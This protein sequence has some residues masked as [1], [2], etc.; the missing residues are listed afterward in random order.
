MLFRW[1]R[2]RAIL[3]SIIVHLPTGATKEFF[4]LNRF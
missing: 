3:S 2:K 1:V 4:C